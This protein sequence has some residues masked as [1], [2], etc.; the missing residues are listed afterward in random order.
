MTA[1]AVVVARFGSP[2][3]PPIRALTERFDPGEEPP[4]WDDLENPTISVSENET[5]GRLIGRAARA[6][7]SKGA[8][9]DKSPK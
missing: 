4:A 6:S 7:A 1:Y 9:I 8:I 3:A 2:M 5:L